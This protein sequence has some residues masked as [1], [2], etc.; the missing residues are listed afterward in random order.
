MPIAEARA[1]EPRLD[2]HEEESE[3]DRRALEE[4]AHWADRYSPIVGLEDGPAPQS[5]LCDITGCAACFHGEEKLLDRA[6]REFSALGWVPR[7]AIADT[8]GAAWAL[9]RY[10]RTPVLAPTSAMEQVLRSLPTAALRLSA[11]LAQT[12][13]QLGIQR[14][15]ALLALPRGELPSRFGL[16]VLQRLDQALGR[17]PEVITPQHALTTIE[18]SQSLEHPTSRFDV[19]CQLIDGLTEQIEELLR[20]RTCAARHIACWL[21]HLSEPPLRID[22]GLY[23]PRRCPGHL[24]HLLRTRLEQIRLKEPLRAV[25]L[26]VMAAESLVDRQAELFAGEPAGIEAASALV[27]YLSTRLG[28]GAVAQARMVPDFQPEYACRLE[29]LIQ[30]P[31]EKRMPERRPPGRRGVERERWQPDSAPFHPVRPLRLWP[32]PVAIEVLALAPDGPPHRLRWAGKEHTIT[33]SWGPERI[34][35]GWW[36]GRDV[37]ERDYYVVDT[38]QGTRLWIF[39]RQGDARW[40]LHGCFD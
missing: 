18:A 33:R 8:I 26:Q 39:R 13:A 27:D 25:R 6:V 20:A 16:M 37:V 30:L 23:Q 17:L 1:I 2:V 19:L 22:V 9:A 29:P 11:D 4:L 40:F 5:L 15:E 21:Y 32:R 3:A 24:A 31:T 10:A 28:P 36:R 7:I 34:E 14:I 12:L 38:S 35:T